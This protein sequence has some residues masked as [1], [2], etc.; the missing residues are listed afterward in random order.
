MLSEQERKTALEWLKSVDSTLEGIE[1]GVKAESL[2]QNVKEVLTLREDRTMGWEA[3]KRFDDIMRLET[4][5]K[6]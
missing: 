3:D 6:D 5:L 4:A 2:E 1:S